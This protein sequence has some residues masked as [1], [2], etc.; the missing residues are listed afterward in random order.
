MCQK[1]AA[2]NLMRLAHAKLRSLSKLSEVLTI[3]RASSFTNHV[4]RVDIDNN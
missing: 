1:K 4:P 2:E 3:I